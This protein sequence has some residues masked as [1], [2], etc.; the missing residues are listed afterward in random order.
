MDYIYIVVCSPHLQH[1]RCDSRRHE[2]IHI[3][4]LVYQTQNDVAHIRRRHG[5]VWIR[6]NI[7]A[8]CKCVCVCARFT[9]ANTTAHDAIAA[10][11]PTNQ[12][13]FAHRCD[14]GAHAFRQPCVALRQQPLADADSDSVAPFDAALHEENLAATRRVATFQQHNDGTSKQ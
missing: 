7:F 1:A 5:P 10:R 4:S 13:R 6:V 9:W 2:I 11:C 3:H 8:V 12:E 14:A